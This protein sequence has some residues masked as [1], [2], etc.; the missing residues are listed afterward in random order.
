MARKFRVLHGR[1]LSVEQAHEKDL[2]GVITCQVSKAKSAQS[3]KSVD[4]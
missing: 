2:T 3:A 1:G 4:D